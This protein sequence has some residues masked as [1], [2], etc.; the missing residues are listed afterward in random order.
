MLL[1]E[2]PYL[3]SYWNSF[4]CWGAHLQVL[5]T[6]ISITVLTGPSFLTKDLVICPYKGCGCNNG[7]NLVI[8][9][10]LLPTGKHYEGND[11]FFKFITIPSTTLCWHLTMTR[12]YSSA[13]ATAEK[14]Q[15]GSDFHRA[16]LAAR[17]RN[18]NKQTDA[19]DKDYFIMGDS[20][21]KLI[22]EGHS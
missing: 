7:W 4:T 11:V 2:A 18:R 10:V 19:S 1:W 13:T 12:H 20:T 3:Q 14:R 17:K 15:R 9:L 8:F 22:W 21:S 5:W 16:H 6:L